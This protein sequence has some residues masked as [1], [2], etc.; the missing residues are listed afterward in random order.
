MKYLIRYYLNGDKTRF[1]ELT[2][3]LDSFSDVLS[4]RVAGFE[5]SNPNTTIQKIVKL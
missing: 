3:E 4:N 1:Y 5:E 2:I